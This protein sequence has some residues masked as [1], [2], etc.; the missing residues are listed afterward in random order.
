MGISVEGQ[1][2]P[3]C[4]SYIFDNDDL[5]F[6][7]ECG[8]PHHR[9]CYEAIGH[10]AYKDKHGTSEGYNPPK[11]K[12]EDVASDEPP[13]EEL[14]QPCRFCG[15]MLS[16]TEKMCHNC[17]RP[18][19]VGGQAPFGFGGPTIIIDSMGGV[20]P[21]EKIGDVTAGE[22][23]DYVAVNTQRYLPKF[24]AIKTRN[25]KT[26]NWAAF[27]VPHVWFLYRKM[28]LPGILFSLLLITVSLFLLPLSEIVRTMPDEAIRSTATLANY[29]VKN[30]STFNA[31][32]VL[33][34]VVS[35]IGELA[36]RLV[37]GFMGDK[38]YL[39][40]VID[41][42]KKV[43]SNEEETEEPLNIALARKGG[44]NIFLGLI[45]MFAFNFVLEWISALYFL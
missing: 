24:K 10:C 13:F 36:I 5:V 26:F 1:K 38:I 45:G 17:G 6:C 43:K 18:Q 8:A 35:L 37:A 19:M 16:P 33:L 23:R 14:K 34:G 9:D 20:S 28:Y 7:P 12:K 3:V 42:I 15:E 44:V 21:N 30:M 29:L 2:C 32:P 31:L 25:K 27:L 11:Q 4:G 39:K 22:V 40:S 41:G